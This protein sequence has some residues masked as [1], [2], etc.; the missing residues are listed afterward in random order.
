MS[1]KKQKNYSAE[2]KIRVIMDMR[3]HHLG[4]C[5][6]ARKYGIV[7][8]S[9]GGAIN[10]IR[11]WERTFL[12]EGAEGLMK[13]RRGRSNT[14]RKREQIGLICTP[15]VRHFW[16]CIFLWVKQE[17]RTEFICQNLKLVL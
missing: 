8:K 16:R 4:Y 17:E 15:K 9:T 12:E 11:R 14:S 6:V 1:K 13:E 2:F 10:T 3:E 7:N 5:E